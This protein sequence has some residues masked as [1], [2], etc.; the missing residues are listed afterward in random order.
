[1]SEFESD[2]MPFVKAMEA[3]YLRHYPQKGESWKQEGQFRLPRSSDTWPQ[4][5]DQ[6]G[7]LRNAMFNCLKKYSRKH[8]PSELVDIANL[9]AMLWMR[10]SDVTEDA[11]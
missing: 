3:E 5:M 7:Y 11:E 2:L 9:C 10:S 1:M 8:D 4:Y 6:D